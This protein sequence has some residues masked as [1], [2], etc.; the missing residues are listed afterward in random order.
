MYLKRPMKYI[1]TLCLT[2]LITI[3]TVAFLFPVYAQGL[4]YHRIV[5][6]GDPHLPYKASLHTDPA[7]QDKVVASKQRMQADING[8]EDVDLIAVLGDMVGDTGTATEYAA[9]RDFFGRFN[10]PIAPIMG[11]HDYI[12][13]ENKN[14]QGY[15]LWGPPDLREQK[16][17]TFKSIFR[18][19][20]VYYTR[21]IGGYLLIFLS[22]D[23]LKDNLYQTQISGRQLDWLAATLKKNAN[24]PTLIFFH[25]PLK[26][27]AFDTDSKDVNKPQFI[28][29]P[30]KPID[31]L[32]RQHPQI[33]AWVSGHIHL[34]PLKPG[35]HAD[36]N[37]YAGRV[38]NIHNTDIDREI[39]WTR[40]LYLYPD[41][42]V[43]R[44]FN[45]K[46]GRW[47]DELERTIPVPH[48]Q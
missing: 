41:K 11:N 38:A 3:L 33:L 35:F 30:E 17:N 12:Y 47:L 21:E 29:Q 5:V 37:M 25:A 10:K 31:E 32:I 6:L 19:G 22:P 14:P 8:W 20:S 24:K 9:V 18:L 48:G 4:D 36:V 45:H 1:K 13:S 27:T 34:S 15:Y 43:V 39:I 40:S 23:M 44:T 46:T 42:V 16:I 28:A 7:K 2:L 26:G